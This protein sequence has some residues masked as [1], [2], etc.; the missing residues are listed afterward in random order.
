MQFFYFNPLAC[1]GSHSSAEK[2]TSLR[3]LCKGLP[4][5]FITDLTYCRSLEY[6]QQPD[7]DHCRRPFRQVFE[8]EGFKDDGVY[9]WMAAPSPG[10]SEKPIDQPSS[11]DIQKSE[12]SEESCLSAVSGDGTTVEHSLISQP[13]TNE[14][15]PYQRLGLKARQVLET[16]H[17]WQL[18]IVLRASAPI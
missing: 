16:I 12:Q 7:Y 11:G 17:F 1:L 15:G 13:E 14:A 10:A 18:N 3:D 8:R 9:D 6:T 2:E 4:Q 5:E